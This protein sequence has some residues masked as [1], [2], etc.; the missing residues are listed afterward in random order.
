M[1]VA[2]VCLCSRPLSRSHR[3]HRC[4]SAMCDRCAAAAAA[5]PHHRHWGP[6]CNP[7]LLHQPEDEDPAPYRPDPSAPIPHR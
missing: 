5:D 4:G 7:Q 3:C 6:E 2:D 1:P